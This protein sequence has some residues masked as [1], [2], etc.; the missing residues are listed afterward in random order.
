MAQSGKRVTLDF[1]SSHDVRVLGSSSA[2]GSVLSGASASPS[3][4]SHMCTGSLSLSEIN[5]E[6]FL[7][8]FFFLIKATAVSQWPEMI[9]RLHS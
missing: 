2:Q 9:G 3:A 4:P 1:G 7:K 8:K 6:I 5:N